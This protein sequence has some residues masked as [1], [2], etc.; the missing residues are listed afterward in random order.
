M[1]FYRKKHKYKTL[2]KNGNKSY[3]QHNI[4][5]VTSY[6]PKTLNTQY[7][8]NQNTKNYTAPFLQQRMCSEIPQ[9]E[10]I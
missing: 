4:Q 2:K 10:K 1:G 6:L 5:P 8:A 9:L 7:K 3:F